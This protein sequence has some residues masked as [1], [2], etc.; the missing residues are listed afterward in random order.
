VA[1]NSAYTAETGRLSQGIEIDDAFFWYQINQ[2]VYAIIPI[3]ERV[4]AMYVVHQAHGTMMS[5]SAYPAFADIGYWCV[6]YV[7]VALNHD[8]ADGW[9]N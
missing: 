1:V 7:W 9:T 3:R 4:V 8:L 2:G 5:D 6:A